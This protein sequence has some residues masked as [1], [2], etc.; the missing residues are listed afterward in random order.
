MDH[1]EGLWVGRNDPEENLAA[2]RTPDRRIN[3]FIPELAE[4]IRSISAESEA[5]ALEPDN[6]Y[7]LLLMA[8]R[9]MDYNVNTQMRDPA[10]NKGHRACTLAMNP[11]DAASL[12]LTDGQMVKITT[13]AGSVEIELE[14]TDSA[15]PGQVI[16]PHGFGL[17]YNGQVYGVNV[18]YLTK[19]THRDRIAGTPLSRFVPCRVEST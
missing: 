15:R 11:K 19:N 17:N 4:W 10:W 13:E 1:P 14:V 7:P 6:D 16:I 2:V 12:N 5:K 8:G 9:H 18:N 3:V